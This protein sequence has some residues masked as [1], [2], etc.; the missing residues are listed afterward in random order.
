MVNRNER[1]FVAKEA[2]TQEGSSF[3]QVSWQMPLPLELEI[4]KE[5]ARRSEEGLWPRVTRLAV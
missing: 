3:L 2:V 4:D 1:S 5:E